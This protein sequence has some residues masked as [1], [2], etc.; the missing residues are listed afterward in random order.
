MPLWLHGVSELVADAFNSLF[1]MQRDVAWSQHAVC[2]LT[3][4]SLFEMQTPRRFEGC[5]DGGNF[6]FSI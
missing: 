2:V 6:Q 5:V 3:F 1:E 4:N